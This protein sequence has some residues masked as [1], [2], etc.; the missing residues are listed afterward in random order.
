MISLSQQNN[1]DN[2][3]CEIIPISFNTYKM[4][5]DNRDF[6][7]CNDK[8]DNEKYL[9]QTCFQAKTSGTKF[10]EVHGV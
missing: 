3:P 5:E 7:K 8:F 10:P 1:D 2:N 9:I 4:L 6:G